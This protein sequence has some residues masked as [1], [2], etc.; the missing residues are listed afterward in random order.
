MVGRIVGVVL[1]AAVA[2]TI[3]ACAAQS[4]GRQSS[5]AATIVASTSS[6]V[7]T[8][9]ASFADPSHDLFEPF[10]ADG[11]LTVRVHGSRTGSCF[12]SSIATPL[13]GAYR[14]LSGNDLLDPCFAS[15]VANPT[16]VVCFADPWSPG[17]SVK[18]TGK[19]PT[20]QPIVRDGLA[21]A[22][23]LANSERCLVMTGALP[24]V[25]GRPLQYRCGDSAVASVEQDSSGRIRVWYG[26]QD[27][28]L[29]PVEVLSDWRA[30]TYV[31]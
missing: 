6:A 24:T 16:S 27:G 23:E 1:G 21:W 4:S 7:P 2:V 8:P 19:L 25:D 5:P 14:C 18:L 17:V 12:T 28:P 11:T 29:Y 30:R 26:P 10:T 9:S 3:A 31:A 22:L 15:P 13:A 20:D